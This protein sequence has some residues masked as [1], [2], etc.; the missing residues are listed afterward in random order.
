[1]LRCCGVGAAEYS[2]QSKTDGRGLPPRTAPILVANQGSFQSLKSV[3]IDQ[4][5]MDI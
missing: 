1:V 5:L 2:G 3:A 4:L